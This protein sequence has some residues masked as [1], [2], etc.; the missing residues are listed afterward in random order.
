MQRE[1]ESQVVDLSVEQLE[2]GPGSRGP[3]EKKRN[4]NYEIKMPELHLITK[5]LGTQ[6]LG[7][8]VK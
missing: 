4:K 2:N 6:V 8:R 1:A 5:V 3:R 7:R